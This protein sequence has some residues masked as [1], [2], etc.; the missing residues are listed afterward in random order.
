[1]YKNFKV[2]T[3]MRK[4]TEKKKILL[5]SRFRGNDRAGDSHFPCVSHVCHSRLDR[6]SSDFFVTFCRLIYIM[7]AYLL[8]WR[9]MNSAGERPDIFLNHLEK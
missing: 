1:M 6:E 7:P 5:D 8:P 3:M 4:I 9:F 2:A